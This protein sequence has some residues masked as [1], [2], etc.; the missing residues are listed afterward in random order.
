MAGSGTPKISMASQYKNTG[1][2]GV[3]KR[4]R[5]TALMAGRRKRKLIQDK[6]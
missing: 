5:H 2:T 3:D 6:S 1:G 4:T